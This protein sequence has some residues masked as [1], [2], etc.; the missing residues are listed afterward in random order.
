MAKID[1][2]VQQ[3]I[4]SY[5]TKKGIRWRVIIPDGRGFQIR[6]QGFVEKSIAVEFAKREYQKTLLQV[7]AGFMP[8]Y[9]NLTFAEYSK[10]WLNLKVR[11]GLRNR[12]VIRYR[13]MIEQYINPFMGVFKLAEL[14]KYHLRNFIT[15]MQ[16]D[17]I[18]TYNVHNAVIITKMMLKQA[19]EDDYMPMSNI[20]TVKVPKHKP[21]DPVFW[22]LDE[23]NFFL[24]AN[25][26][27]PH[28]HIWKFALYT[29]MRA[30][31]VAGLMWDCVHFEM[32]SGDHKGFITVKRTCE[33]KTRKVSELTKNGE[34]RLIPIF[35]QIRDML[36]EMK[37][38]SEGDFVFGGK[39]PME[40]SHFSRL[41][42]QELNQIPQLKKVTFHGLR[43]SFCSY[44]DST[45]M[46]RRIVSEIMGHRDLNTTNRYSH[47]SNKTLANEMTRWLE[48]QNQQNSNKVGLV[49]L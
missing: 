31:E 10:I 13:D 23:F 37:A 18:S 33:Q 9:A 6:Q 21:K 27:S 38:K 16:D 25:L 48:N 41:L 35:P 32:K 43:H 12:T 36:I 14:Q 47:V 34:K 45:G 42:K 49:A 22:D 30:S 3:F 20:L 11:D 1:K 5:L 4:K 7:N 40:T 24:N 8:Q 44:L 26:G 46:S 29:G 39:E 15:E 2:E 19:I 28:H 17:N